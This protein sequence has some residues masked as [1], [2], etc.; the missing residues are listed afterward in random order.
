M[1]I[2]LV[3][4]N[5]EASRAAGLVI[6]CDRDGIEVRS[7]QP[8][9]SFSKLALEL[10]CGESDAEIANLLQQTLVHFETLGLIEKLSE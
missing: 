1:E 2:L 10:E 7:N 6:L 3:G 9:I 8:G 5:A 4:Q